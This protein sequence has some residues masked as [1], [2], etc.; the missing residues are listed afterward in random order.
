MASSTLSCAT[1]RALDPNQRCWSTHSCRLSSG[2][3]PTTVLA[4]LI[5]FDLVLVGVLVLAFL[6][7]GL[8]VLDQL[9]PVEAAGGQR[10]DVG[11][12]ADRREPRAAEDLDRVAALEAREVELDRLRRAGEVV[13]AQHH[14]VL[15]AAH[16]REDARI[17]RLE[18]LER[19]EAE[20]WV[21][22]AQRDEAAQPS[23]QAGRRAQLRLDV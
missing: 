5:G 9:E 8:L 21:L 19:A 6:R 17:A 13:H 20:D 3:E 23:Q 22:L 16:V 12:I 2:T 18:R 15:V 10:E 14:V 4:S 11:Q 7:R 1:S